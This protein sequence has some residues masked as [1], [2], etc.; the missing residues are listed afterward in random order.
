MRSISR[1]RL[2]GISW[3][4]DRAQQRLRDGRRAQ[5]PQPACAPRAPR[6][7]AGRRRN[8]AGTRSG[9]RRARARS[10]SSSI[11]AS[12]GA[13]S[14]IDAVRLLPGAAPGPAAREPGDQHAVDHAAR[15]VAPVPQVARREY[16]PRGR[17]AA[18]I[19]E[20]SACPGER[21]RRRDRRRA[22]A[23]R[24]AWSLTAGAAEELC[25]R[26]G[27][28]R[29]SRARGPPSRAARV[30]WRKESS[31]ASVSPV[32]A[33]PSAS[34]QRAFPFSCGYSS[35]TASS[36]ARARRS[37]LFAVARA[38]PRAWPGRCGGPRD[39][40]VSGL[41]PKSCSA[42]SKLRPASSARPC[43]IRMSPREQ[44]GAGEMQRVV[45]HG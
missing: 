41:G 45:G 43:A 24:G 36:A 25:P 14:W 22:R 2:A 33:R 32:S 34:A 44:V 29:R 18:E 1:A 40:L 28:P 4:A 38:V 21:A 26:P 17:T 10:A 31:A 19:T 23:P 7:S 15:G 9:R 13:R 39:R 20:A 5:R 30:A 8:G 11:P 27:M 35:P 37:C 12:S 3:P 42:R 6:R 16:R